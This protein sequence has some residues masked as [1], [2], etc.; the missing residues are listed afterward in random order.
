MT[1][2]AGMTRQSIKIKAVLLPMGFEGTRPDCAMVPSS[3][4]A[5]GATPLPSPPPQ[6][7][8]SLTTV[9]T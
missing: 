4:I 5:P 1:G 3:S 2:K 7:G 9:L 6:G 8:G